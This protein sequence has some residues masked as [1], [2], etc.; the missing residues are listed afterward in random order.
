M[1]ACMHIIIMQSKLFNIFYFIS[2]KRAATLASSSSRQRT[3]IWRSYSRNSNHL[4]SFATSSRS[5]AAS[6]GGCGGGALNL[7]PVGRI[8]AGGVGDL[9]SAM[10]S[11][12]LV[13]DAA[14]HVG[15]ACRRRCRLCQL[16][17]MLSVCPTACRR[18]SR[19]YCRR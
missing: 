17:A 6:A 3:R 9:S 10:V 4:R 7:K 2:A 5:S 16:S 1:H 13:G 12:M 15:D 11:A 8:I 14:D 19:R 18:Y